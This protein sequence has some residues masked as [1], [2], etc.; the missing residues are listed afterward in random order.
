MADLVFD[1]INEQLNKLADACCGKPPTEDTPIG[2]DELSTTINHLFHVF[3]HETATTR[4]TLY[5]YDS[6]L[7]LLNSRAQKSL[8]PS[9]LNTWDKRYAALRNVYHEY[10]DRSLKTRGWNW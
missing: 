7:R 10:W 3:Y 6:Q 1:W 8:S 2:Y 5:A 4:K 9:E